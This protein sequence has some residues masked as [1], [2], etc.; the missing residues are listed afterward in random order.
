MAASLAPAVPGGGPAEPVRLRAAVV[1]ETAAD[2]GP[3]AGRT[4][5]RDPA[6][7]RDSV[8]GRDRPGGWPPEPVPL[9]A[10]DWLARLLAASLDPMLRTQPGLAAG[11]R[12][13]AARA[14]SVAAA[15][16]EI[17]RLVDAAPLRSPAARAWAV[18]GEISR[19]HLL[20]A[21][22]MRRVM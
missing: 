4:E 11:A 1:W 19:R 17:G 8:E 14:G 3:V 15:A 2:R 9:P 6:E 10:A 7:S 18:F 16:R 5:T 20:P 13:Y 12:R 22:L 21:F